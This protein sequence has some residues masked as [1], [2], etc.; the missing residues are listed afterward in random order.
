[1]PSRRAEPQLIET[2]T[3]AKELFAQFARDK[4]HEECVVEE[5]RL[6]DELHSLG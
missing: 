6:V 1:M 2:Q 5:E 4:F 3:V